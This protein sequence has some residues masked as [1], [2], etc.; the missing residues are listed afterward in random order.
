MPRFSPRAKK[1]FD[2]IWYRMEIEQ[3]KLIIKDLTNPFTITFA[4]IWIAYSLFLSTKIDLAL[5]ELKEL[6]TF[7]YLNIISNLQ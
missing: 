7:F 4:K 3:S 6:E 2:W 1:I 5:V